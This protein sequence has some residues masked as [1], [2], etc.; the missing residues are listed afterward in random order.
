MSKGNTDIP[1]DEFLILTD[2]DGN[3]VRFEFL[4]VVAYEGSEYVFL[5]P[6]DEESNELIVLRVEEGDDDEVAYVGVGD[7]ETV[8]ALYDIFKKEYK[9]VFNFED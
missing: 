8:A 7:D 3:E 1:G 2:E 4:D 6:A 9:D 5:L